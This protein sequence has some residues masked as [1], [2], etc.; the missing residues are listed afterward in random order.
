MNVI[1]FMELLIKVKAVIKTRGGKPGVV[2]FFI[3]RR[4]EITLVE[5]VFTEIIDL[6]F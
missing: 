5:Q 3:I 6:I 1:A 2:S 4:K